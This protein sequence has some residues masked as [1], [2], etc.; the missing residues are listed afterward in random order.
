LSYEF[1]CCRRC[2]TTYVTTYDSQQEEECEDNFRKNCFIEYETIAFNQTAKVSYADSPAQVRSN[3]L[4][5]GTLGPALV[6]SD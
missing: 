2:H 4:V 1:R 6:K 5:R 3:S